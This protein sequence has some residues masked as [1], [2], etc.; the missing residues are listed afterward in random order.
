V[1]AATFLLSAAGLGL[2][3]TDVPAVGLAMTPLLGLSWISVLTALN[4][5]AQSVLPN[6]VRGRG[7]ALY[8]TV[9]SGAMALG[10]LAWG[11]IAQSTSTQSSLAIA[12]LLGALVALVAARVPLPA[13]E[14]D[15]S[16]SMHWPEPAAAMPMAADA[17]PV[18]VTVEYRIA[19]EDAAAF[20]SAIQALGT[21]RRRDGA[22][23][24]GVFQDTELPERHLEYFIVESWME[25][26]RQHRRVS[27]A[28][29][30]LQATILALHKG[31]G[32]PQISHMI[33][34][35]KGPAAAGGTGGG[36]D[37]PKHLI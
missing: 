16:P 23:A 25:H 14:D 4:V 13:G 21:T 30:A 2:A 12:A 36:L 15:L 18:M 37:H 27:R 31:P 35:G 29:E 7:L 24:W 6:W 17:G 26:L 32:R 20:A 9:F 10:S 5:T 8:L 28:D 34:L 3:A 11:Q 19:A 33:A 1:L 22:Y